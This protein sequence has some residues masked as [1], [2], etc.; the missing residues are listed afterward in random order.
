M[1]QYR[2]T[3]EARRAKSC[4]F[5]ECLRRQR[6]Q[7]VSRRGS[8]VLWMVVLL[9]AFAAIMCY[10]ALENR[11][12]GRVRLAVYERL[13]QMFPNARVVLK[14]V[15]MEGQNQIA[16]HGVHL[17]VRDGGQVRQVLSID[18]LL[19]SGD[20]D[21]AHVV[22][23]TV[24]VLRV[25]VY[26][27][28]VDLWQ[29]D[30]GAWSLLAMKCQSNHDQSPPTVHIHDG[31]LRVYRNIRSGSKPLVL[32]DISG[33]FSHVVALTANRMMQGTLTASSSGTCESIELNATIDHQGGNWSISGLLRELRFS[34]DLVAKLPESLRQQLTQL[35]G[36]SCK[37]SAQY[38]I[39]KK[40][41][42][43]SSRFRVEGKLDEGRLQDPRLP[44]PLEELRGDFFVANGTL[45]LRGIRARSGQTSI[46]LETDILGFSPQAPIVLVAEANMLEL[47]GRV[48]NALPAKWRTYWDRVRPEGFV[49]AKVWLTS[50]GTTWK[51][52]LQIACRDVRLECWL[53]PYR[54]SNVVG[55]VTI[56]SD[57][58]EGIALSGKANGQH[59]HGS[60]NFK[61][62]VEE[63]YGRM[64]LRGS[65]ASV[66]DDRLLT[67][68]SVRG[69]PRSNAERFLRTLELNG[70]FQVKKAIFERNAT[71][72][73]WH[74][75]LDIAVDDCSIVYENFRYPLHQIRGRVLAKDDHW[76]LEGFEGW[77]DNGRIRC[78][79]QWVDTKENG[80]PFELAFTAYSLP[81]EDDLKNALPADARQLWEQIRPNGTL[82]KAIV[83]IRR[84]SG[85]A[86]VEVVV[87]L[88]EENNGLS[89]TGQSLGLHPRSFPYRLT[90]VACDVTYGSGKVTI[91]QASATNTNSRVSL[92][93]EC[94]KNA[95]G[96]WEGAVHWLPSS[97]IIVDSQLIRALPDS[98]NSGLLE[99]DLRGPVNVRGETLFELPND[100][101]GSLST[102]WNLALDLEDVQ[103]GD[104]K[105][106]DGIRGTLDLVG[107]RDQA[108][109]TMAGRVSV[110]AVS[111][112]GIP[113]TNVRGPIAIVGNQL[114]FGSDVA[115]RFNRA[116]GLEVNEVT[117]EA[118]SGVLLL[119]GSGQ[120]E[121]GRFQLQSKLVNADLRSMLQ[122]LGATQAPTDARCQAELNFV[123]VPW[124]VQTYNGN[125]KVQLTDARLYEL[126]TMI[127]L[128][129]KLSITPTENT[130]FHTA[131][132][133]FTIDGDRIPLELACEG[134]LL[135]LRGNGW[136]NLR[137]EVEIDLYSY[138]GGRKPISSLLSP[139][140]ADSRYATFMK[141]E[142]TGTLDN[143][144]IE[145]LAFP[146]LTMREQIFPDKLHR[147]DR[148]ARLLSRLRGTSQ[149]TGPSSNSGSSPILR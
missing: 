110:D 27:P 80:V 59:I 13:S 72:L 122:D 55:Q 144:K 51:P 31:Q 87:D 95:S 88:H 84:K 34:T 2:P 145:R 16:V 101:A 66:I 56:A 75:E 121:S 35:A 138:V 26:H 54:L 133:N 70:N 109:L 37:A 29:T 134:D 20:L 46:K 77:N 120:L 8:A 24:R 97:R 129:R 19:L 105:I 124:Q 82:D 113:V 1:I 65:G 94:Q 130:A 30:S 142:V 50:D 96:N 123:G 10:K 135:S 39:E 141:L 47:D 43:P 60:F 14:S 32:H 23:E 114:Y 103:V 116:V 139:L 146:Q 64:E 76:R 98:I 126:P 63:W 149:P 107:H 131:N 57:F 67:A 73:V 148:S 6:T 90:D 136:T 38:A 44:Y 115:G 92:R 79:G 143:P 117:A 11:V 33:Q 106:I 36:L 68:M 102:N 128:L 45:K 127:Q 17:L 58:L 108:N 112:R 52:T 12:D 4:R 140:I 85:K 91:T 74:R 69:Q 99:L 7:R 125:G 83:S 21:I 132:I 18:R 78:D 42:D 137:R 3:A 28:Q 22:Q 71:E 9:A 118:L 86:S 62:L 100:P 119:S 81:M 5:D 111:V 49:D 61:R 93:A 40:A 41:G 53:F 104:G 48:Y 15:S 89:G 25:D 147:D